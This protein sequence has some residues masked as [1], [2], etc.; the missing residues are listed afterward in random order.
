M[1]LQPPGEEERGLRLGRAWSGLDAL[2]SLGFKAY[3]RSDYG[4]SLLIKGQEVV[5]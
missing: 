5:G 3:R 2:K 1:E 4:P